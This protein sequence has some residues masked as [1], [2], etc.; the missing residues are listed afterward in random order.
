M[1]DVEKLKEKID[2]SGLKIKYLAEQ[3]GLSYQGLRK[4]ITGETEFN[5]S[6]IQNMSRLLNLSQKD[7]RLI[8]FA[9]I[10]DK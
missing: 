6:Q 3:L 10:V 1:T 2:A 9:D 4:K 5:G 8:F 7:I